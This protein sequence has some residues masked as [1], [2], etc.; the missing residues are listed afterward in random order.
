MA[1]RISGEARMARGAAEAANLLRR[2]SSPLMRR[3]KEKEAICLRVVVSCERAES[4]RILGMSISRPSGP[5]E[6]MKPPARAKGAEQTPV[7]KA[8][9]NAKARSAVLDQ[10]P[11]HCACVHSATRRATARRGSTASGS[12][13]DSGW[14][15]T[16]GG[17]VQPCT[18]AAQTPPAPRKVR[19]MSWPCVG[20]RRE[21]PR[22]S[23][24]VR[25]RSRWSDRPARATARP[26]GPDA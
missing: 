16:A 1:R 17:A 21:G 8:M 15:G 2:A 14:R 19:R 12:G 3:C 20:S 11:G 25:H 5:T 9:T 23:P 6:K 4:A 24:R 13:R 18:E 22:R 7:P 26:F 10:K